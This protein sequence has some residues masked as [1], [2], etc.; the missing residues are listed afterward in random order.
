[1]RLTITT[2][3]ASVTADAASNGLFPAACEL[4]MNAPSP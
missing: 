3:S 2:N 1:M 4:V